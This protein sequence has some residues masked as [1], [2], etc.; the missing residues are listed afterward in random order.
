[1]NLPSSGAENDG[2]QAAKERARHERVDAPVAHENRCDLHAFS[3]S[4]VTLMSRI[5]HGLARLRVCS[6]SCLHSGAD[7]MASSGA[8]A[9][10]N[11]AVWRIYPLNDERDSADGA[12]QKS[13]KPYETRI[14]VYLSIPGNSSMTETTAEGDGDAGSEALADCG[15]PPEV[16]LTAAELLPPFYRQVKGIARRERNRLG[17]VTLQTTSSRIRRIC[18]CVARV[19]MPTR[20]ISSGQRLWPCAHASSTM[21]QSGWPRSAVAAPCT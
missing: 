2:L 8:L 11:R 19:A 15:A 14:G 5:A 13:L 21:P 1:M 17:A 7:P 3:R 6:H 12:A 20:L 4:E 18:G 16:R 10:H 9:R